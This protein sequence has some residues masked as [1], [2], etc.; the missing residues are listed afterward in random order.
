MSTIMNGYID[1]LGDFVVPRSLHLAEPFHGGLAMAKPMGSTSFGFLDTRGVW[2]MEPS[3]D[4]YGGTKNGIHTFNIGGVRGERG[5]EGGAWG[6]AGDGRILAEPKFRAIGKFADGRIPVSDG[7]KWGYSDKNGELVAAVRFDMAGEF[8][9]GAAV[10]TMDG[11]SAYLKPDGTFLLQPRDFELFTFSETRGRA[12]RGNEWFLISSEGQEV[13]G[14]YD[15]IWPVRGGMA[16]VRRGDKLAFVSISGSQIGS[17]WFD[18]AR[19][20]GCGLAP[21][22]IGDHWFV[23]REGGELHGPFSS[24]GAAKQDFV[25]IVDDDGVGFLRRDG[26][27]V[28][29]A[30]ESGRG[31]QNGYAGVR[32]EGKWTFIDT[33]G[34]ELHEPRWDD[35]GAYSAGGVCPTRQGA[36]WGVC[37]RTGRVMVNHR[38]TRIGEFSEGLASAQ[39]LNWDREINPPTS[40]LTAMPS[41]GLTHPVFQHTTVDDDLRVTVLFE[42]TLSDNQLLQLRHLC[43]GAKSAFDARAEGGTSLFN[44]RFW[45]CPYAMSMRLQKLPQ[46]VVSADVLMDAIEVLGLPVKEV[47]FLLLRDDP[48]IPDN[49]HMFYPF[50]PAAKHPDDPLGPNSFPDFE[51]YWSAVWDFDAVAPR[52]ENL[53]YLRIGRFDNDFKV[54]LAE[55]L[56]SLHVPDVRLCVGTMQVPSSFVSRDDARTDQ[57]SAVLAAKVAERFSADRVWVP[58]FVKNYRP[59]FPAKGDWTPGVMTVEHQGRKGYSFAFDAPDLIQDV[60]PDIFRYREQ[61]I[62]DALAEAIGE[63][64]LE[65]VILWQL[66]SDVLNPNMPHYAGIARISTPKYYICQVWEK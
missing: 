53:F 12:R 10:V 34:Q 63:L 31:F 43:W 19:W 1:R 57:V 5:I 55:R 61:E 48:E 40:K 56:L 41:G 36:R 38:F 23:L 65:P 33:E 39:R 4:W 8:V 15:E 7:S 32:R 45:L 25:A 64:D 2:V 47:T 13:T 58:P 11:K 27:V 22:R 17:D 6:L 24:V 52:S 46:P 54:M 18:E 62:M 51:T 49:W 30:Y 35:V 37:D 66:F 42:P 20:Y 29:S 21:V 59:P 60:G 44:D 9:D 26:V 14:S 28:A 3:A 16:Q 50:K